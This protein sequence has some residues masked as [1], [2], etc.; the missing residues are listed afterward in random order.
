MVVVLHIIRYP[1][2]SQLLKGEHQQRR[3]AHGYSTQQATGYLQAALPQG[4]PGQGEKHHVGCRDH[5]QGL[6]A[7][8]HPSLGEQPAHGR[9]DQQGTE[10]ISDVGQLEAGLLFRAALQPGYQRL[11]LAGLQD[12][13]V[14]CAL[15]IPGCDFER[16]DQFYAFV[17]LRTSFVVK[18]SV[19]K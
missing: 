16:H 6:V 13:V 1:E 15:K 5:Q 19:T 14:D 8:A 18:S 7:D 10:V 17:G 2:S 3:Q 9:D 4:A 12:A 11:V